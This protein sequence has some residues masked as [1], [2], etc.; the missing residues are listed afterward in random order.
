MNP[1]NQKNASHFNADEI[2]SAIKEW[3]DLNWLALR[4]HVLKQG[5]DAQKFA[6]LIDEIQSGRRKVS[7][8]TIWTINY[9][10]LDNLL[11]DLNRLK[12]AAISAPPVG[13]VGVGDKETAEVYRPDYRRDYRKGGIKKTT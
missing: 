2:K 1:I 8:K 6:E 7:T 10:S 5:Y 13:R 9:E 11:P 3:G 12:V 4:V